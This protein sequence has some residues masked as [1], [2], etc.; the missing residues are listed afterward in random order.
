[1]NDVYRV[2]ADGGTPMIVSGDRYANEFFSAVSPDGKTLAMSARGNASGQWWRH[3]HSHLD[4]AEIWLRDLT[5]PDSP[6]A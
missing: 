6:S 2:A 3:G 5:A 4:E 1:M